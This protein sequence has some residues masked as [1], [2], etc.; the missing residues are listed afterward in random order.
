[1]S[2]SE[3]SIFDEREDRGAFVQELL[4]STLTEQLH[5]EQDLEALIGSGSTTDSVK[6]SNKLQPLQTAATSNDGDQHA[7]SNVGAASPPHQQNTNNQSKEPTTAA[8][9]AK[10][11][12]PEKQ[13]QH[14][15]GGTVAAHSSR[16]SQGHSFQSVPLR[17][18][19]GSLSSGGQVYNSLPGSN[20]VQALAGAGIGAGT[21]HPLPGRPGSGGRDRDGRMNPAAAKKNMFKQLPTSQATDREPPPH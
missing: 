18:N 15:G 9:I 8:A 11:V 13:K 16:P 5:L 6:R 19:H 4:L 12:L 20:A 17:Q 7:S 2:E 3:Q 14:A 10:S 21:L 1:M